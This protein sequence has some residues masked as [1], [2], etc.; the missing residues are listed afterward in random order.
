MPA[1]ETSNTLPWGSRV[2]TIATVTFIAENFEVTSPT[3]VIERMDEVGN[4]NGAVAIDKAR[5]GTAT[6]QLASEST[7]VPARGAEF[8]ADTVTYF[9]TE[10]SAPEA[11]EE[12][13]TVRISFR[14]KI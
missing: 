11:Q 13:K 4:P 3:N 7:V 1:Y 14:Q 6:L 2:L 5:T 9:L 10:V 12:F 8:T